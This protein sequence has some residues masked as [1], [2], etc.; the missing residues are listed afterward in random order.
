[1]SDAGT[2]HKSVTSVVHCAVAGLVFLLFRNETKRALL[3]NE[4]TTLHT[5]RALFASKF[6]PAITMQ[7]FEQSGAKVYIQDVA[8]SVFYE[9]EDMW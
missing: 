2:E 7:W 5:L 9:L 8:T 4:V 6:S 3:P 1:M